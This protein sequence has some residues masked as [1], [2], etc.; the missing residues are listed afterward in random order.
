MGRRDPVLSILFQKLGKQLITDLG[1][2]GLLAPWEAIGRLLGCWQFSCSLP[3]PRP[4][5]WKAGSKQGKMLR[6]RE[7]KSKLCWLVLGEARSISEMECLQKKIPQ[8]I[9]V[10][11][12]YKFLELNFIGFLM[13]GCAAVQLQAYWTYCT[14]TEQDVHK[15]NMSTTTGLWFR[16]GSLLKGIAE[17]ALL[18]V[19]I[20]IKVRAGPLSS[21]LKIR[22]RDVF[23]SD[24]ATAEELESN[25]KP[26]DFPK[27][28]TAKQV[29]SLLMYGFS[30]IYIY[31]TSITVSSRSRAKYSVPLCWGCMPS[32]PT[33]W[34]LTLV[35]FL[36]HFKEDICGY[37][38]QM[39]T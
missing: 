16:G 24:T 37:G 13:N 1:V 8:L 14:G 28:F 12:I 38:W 39:P 5:K 2:H 29:Q 9:F 3:F 20:E 22:V 34:Y 35:L 6:Q 19:H 10:L 23:V 32:L 26:C 11:C 30:K 15:P 18:I 33:L 4:V 36:P 27:I 31:V 25:E 7:I 17:A 21:L